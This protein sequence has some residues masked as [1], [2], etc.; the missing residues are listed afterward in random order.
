M[1]IT[2][3]VAM[4][5]L[6]RYM[7]FPFKKKKLMS[8]FSLTRLF[9]HSVLNIYICTY[10][11]IHSDSRDWTPPPRHGT[12]YFHKGKRTA[13]RIDKQ[14]HYNF[15]QQKINN[16]HQETGFIFVI[17]VKDIFIQ[18]IQVFTLLFLSFKLSCT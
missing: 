17:Q 8:L 18:E 9:P 15:G 3:W 1:K 4:F 5:P 10:E 6:S 13:L 2:Q 14:K 11:P 12:W 16:S 7:M